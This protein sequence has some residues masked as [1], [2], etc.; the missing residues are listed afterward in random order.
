MSRAAAI[1][2]VGFLV[3][4]SGL[5]LS[6]L[7]L[8]ASPRVVRQPLRRTAVVAFAKRRRLREDDYDDGASSTEW[9]ADEQPR[10]RDEDCGDDV[11]W[12]AGEG[13]RRDAA[14][15]V[16]LWAQARGRL[17]RA[18]DTFFE[19]E[20]PAARGRVGQDAAVGSGAR[21]RRRRPAARPA[22]AAADAFRELD[23]DDDVDAEFGGRRFVERWT[24]WGRC[25]VLRPPDEDSSGSSSGSSSSSSGSSSGRGLPLAPVGVVHLIGGAVVGATPKLSYEGLCT[26]LADRGASHKQTRSTNLAFC[27]RT[28][29]VRSPDGSKLVYLAWVWRFQS[30]A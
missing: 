25:D 23:D 20:S 14:G 6:P 2:V 8:V 13:P 27:R 16:P 28:P 19:E 17:Q 29:R 12:F 10:R 26:K 5:Q 1:A 11:D 15:R 3:V 18:A 22:P 7:Q 30:H 24:T 21:P 4:S 9:F